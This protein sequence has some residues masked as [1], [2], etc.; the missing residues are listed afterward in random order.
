[1]YF[2]NIKHIFKYLYFFAITVLVFYT[3]S[4]SVK[5]STYFVG[6]AL[7]L[8]GYTGVF[9]ILRKLDTKTS[10]KSFLRLFF[11]C[12]LFLV[13]FFG[14]TLISS[15]FFN[16]KHCFDVNAMNIFTKQINEYCGIP[17]WY[18]RIVYTEN[19]PIVTTGTLKYWEE[20]N[21]ISG[22]QAKYIYINSNK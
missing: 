18:T 1:M 16:T 13:V 4:S 15:P 3:F 12:T 5:A 19:S 10:L 22:F 6:V 7:S 9:F 14:S 8:I 11:G 17:P 20:K 2:V 21:L